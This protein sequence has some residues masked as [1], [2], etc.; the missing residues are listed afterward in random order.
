MLSLNPRRVFL[1]GVALAALVAGALALISSLGAQ[2]S[3]AAVN[4]NHITCK[5]FIKSAE[6]NPDDP[7]LYQAQYR[8]RC[9]QA[10]TGY[11]LF[12][13][14]QQVEGLET[15]TVPLFADG[16]VV[17]ADA[18][19]CNGD[20]PGNGVNCVGKYSDL[21]GIITGTFAVAQPLCTA[22]KRIEPILTVA[23]ASVSSANKPVLGISG[24]FTLGQSSDCKGKKNKPRTMP[25]MPKPEVDEVELGDPGY[26]GPVTDSRKRN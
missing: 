24:P 8:I 18:F 26:D 6:A 11:S 2:P 13:S 3:R 17:A 16:S 9:D 1:I 5:G 21:A 20:L 22:G 23:T 10:I 12:I 14:A 25:L 7:E 4:D 19:S 15:E